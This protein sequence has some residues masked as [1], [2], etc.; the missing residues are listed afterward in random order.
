MVG[1]EIRKRQAHRVLSVALILLLFAGT[2]RSHDPGAFGGLFRSRDYGATW[3][4][5]NQGAFLS[6]A[7]SLAISPIDHN[8]LLL[9]T[10]SGLFASRNGGRDWDVEAPSLI[11]GSVFALE[12]QQGWAAGT[13]FDGCGALQLRCG[14]CLAQGASALGCVASPNHRSRQPV[15][16]VLSGRQRWLVSQR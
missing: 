1:A 9:G 3:V 2:A 14:S 8:H 13:G 16:S 5:A 7:I 6:G 11:L 4:S 12:F 15:R 10:E